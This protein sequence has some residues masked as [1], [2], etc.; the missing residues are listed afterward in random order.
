MPAQLMQEKRFCRQQSLN[1]L[2]NPIHR[3]HLNIAGKSSSTTSREVN[4]HY[5]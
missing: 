3:I 1:F 4:Y 5:L 2:I